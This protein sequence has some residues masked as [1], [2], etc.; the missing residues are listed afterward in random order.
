MSRSRK[1]LNLPWSSSQSNRM[2]PMAGVTIW[3]L[4]PSSVGAN[5]LS[6]LA[7]QRTSTAAE[8]SPN[9]EFTIAVRKDP[10]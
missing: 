2:A 1:K 10:S 4:K 9:S 7:S 5:R 6:S 8:P 3:E